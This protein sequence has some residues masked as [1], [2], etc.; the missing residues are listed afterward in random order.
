MSQLRMLITSLAAALAL[1]VVG[2][3]FAGT[4][5][6][7]A[8]GLHQG[9]PPVCLSSCMGDHDR[10]I[11]RR[12]FPVVRPIV[13]VVYPRVVTPVVIVPQPVVYTVP[14]VTYSV[15]ATVCLPASAYAS[16]TSYFWMSYGPN[17]NSG[18]SNIQ[19][20][21]LCQ[22]YNQAVLANPA[23]YNPYVQ[24]VC[25]TLGVSGYQYQYPIGVSGP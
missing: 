8:D 10:D 17:W 1:A 21:R 12:I 24:A 2:P 16:S 4:L 23:A 22:V 9:R 11:D 3:L 15:S 6:A 5:P 25:N 20:Q 14:T 18:C 7:F 13:T 19:L